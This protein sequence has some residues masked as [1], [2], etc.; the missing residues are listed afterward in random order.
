MAPSVSRTSL[1]VRCCFHDY[2]IGIERGLGVFWTPIP[3][4]CLACFVFEHV[5]DYAGVGLGV[6]FPAT[7]EMFEEGS[8][9]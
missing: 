7:R 1:A 3:L 6:I 4:R 5:L 9:Y 2:C 8:F